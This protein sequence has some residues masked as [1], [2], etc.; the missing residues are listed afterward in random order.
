MQCVLL[1]WT[2]ISSM[3]QAY[4]VGF[5]LKEEE[6]NRKKKGKENR[7]QQKCQQDWKNDLVCSE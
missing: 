2:D 7:R 5:F 3:Y 1:I 4:K 6:E